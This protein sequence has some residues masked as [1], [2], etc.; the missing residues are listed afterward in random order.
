MPGCLRALAGAV[1][2][3]LLPVSASAEDATLFRLFL[4][5]GVVVTSY[6]EYARVGDRVVFSTPVGGSPEAPRL[7]LVTLAV[8]RVDWLRTEAYAAAAR[9]RHYAATRGEEDFAQLSNEVARTLNDIALTTDRTQALAIAR[10]AR[11]TLATWPIEHYG[12]RQQDV[13]EIVGLLDEAIAGLQG[14]RGSAGF[15]LALVAVPS[16]STEL[17]LG[18]PAVPEQLRSVLALADIADSPADRLALLNAAAA[19]L[20]EAGAARPASGLSP[21]EAR[22]RQR[23]IDDL[24]ADERTID[25]RYQDLAA[26]VT[27]RAARAAARAD[28]TGVEKAMAALAAGD[29]RLGQRRPDTARAARGILDAHLAAAQRLRLLRDRWALRR[30]AYRAYRRTVG[31]QILTLVRTRPQIESIRRLDGPSPDA[32]GELRARLSGG[33]ERLHRM[34]VD[35]DLQDVHAFAVSAWQFAESAVNARFD[36]VASGSVPRAREASSAAAAALMMLSRAQEE[37]R[38]RLERPE[39]P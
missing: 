13:R 4:I 37:L 23:A 8:T 31:R 18:P 36:A 21:A 33:A 6:G 14:N 25:E 19:L 39:L 32:L 1:L 24:I 3:L 10:L 34:T 16:T 2:C 17:V 20:R 12:Y 9:A 5:D 15:D 7:Q 27:R 35:D 28:V 38:R 22:R 11:R 30:A 26:K 29:A